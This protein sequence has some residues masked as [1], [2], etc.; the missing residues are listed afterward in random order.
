MKFLLAAALPV[1]IFAVSPAAA[2]LTDPVRMM[3]EAAI[4]SGKAAEVDTVAKY[5]KKAQPEEAEEIAALVS[6]WKTKVQERKIADL[7]NANLFERWDGEGHLGFSRSTGNSNDTG[8]NA[9]LRLKREGVSWTH[10]LRS[11]IDYQKSKD[12]V[13]R[14]RIL[15]ALESQHRFD[16]TAFAFGQGQFERDRVQGIA[17][18]YAISGGLGWTV[19]DRADLRLALKGGPAY[20]HTEYRPDR[21]ED[22]ITGLAALDGRWTIASGLTLTQRAETFLATDNSTFTSTTSVDTRIIGALAARLSY[23]VDYQTE[24]LA[25]GVDLNTL[26]RASLV[27]DF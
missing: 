24:P 22:V 9:G 7:K 18:R 13:T 8:F 3:L 14:E 15:A 17:A 12:L 6:G 4:E 21:S 1:A 11:Q 19:I 23:T 26:S 5:A 20:R 10:E 16:Q 27:Y 2:Q 25:G